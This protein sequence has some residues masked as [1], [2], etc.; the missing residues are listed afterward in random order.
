MNANQ[1]PAVLMGFAFF[2]IKQTFE[3]PDNRTTAANGGERVEWRP[4]IL[5]KTLIQW[6]VAL[7][8]IAMNMLVLVEG[9]RPHKTPPSWL[10]P[11][12]MFSIFGVSTIAWGILRIVERK[13][14]RNSPI[15]IRIVKDGQAVREATDETALRRAKLEG[16]SRIIVYEV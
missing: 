14:S 4:V 9:A 1:N 7:L 16:N 10:W 6:P 8:F 5:K 3:A 13:S 2:Y 12:I 15:E 11:I